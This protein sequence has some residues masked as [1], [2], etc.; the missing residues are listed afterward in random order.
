[1]ECLQPYAN[2]QKGKQTVKQNVLNFASI[3]NRDYVF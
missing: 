3:Y 2:S 1:M